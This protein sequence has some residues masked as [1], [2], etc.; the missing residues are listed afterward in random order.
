MNFINFAMVSNMI[1]ITDKKQDNKP[2]MEFLMVG[3][4]APNWD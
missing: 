4:T 3:F 1:Y 2:Q